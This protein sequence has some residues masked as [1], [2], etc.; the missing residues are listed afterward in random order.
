MLTF[1]LLEFLVLGKIAKAQKH[2]TRLPFS[3]A[4]C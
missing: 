2:V 4:Q 1:F 3:A